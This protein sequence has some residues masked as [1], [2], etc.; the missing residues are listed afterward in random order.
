M[1]GHAAVD[2]SNNHLLSCW[3]DR[4]RSSEADASWRAVVNPDNERAED[5][6]VAVIL[7]TMV[8]RGRHFEVHVM[9]RL[10]AQRT[11]LVEAQAEAEKLL[12][13]LSWSQRRITPEWAVHYHFGPTLE[14]TEPMTAWVGSR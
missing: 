2:T 4:L 5:L 10:V 6:G 8:G 14:F 9:D 13:P 11:S 1:M 12:G 7:S 3:A